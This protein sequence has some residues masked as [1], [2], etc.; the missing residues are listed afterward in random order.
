MSGDAF[1]DF[2]DVQ[3]IDNCEVT[4]LR[5]FGGYPA[6][7]PNA[8]AITIEQEDTRDIVMMPLMLLGFQRVPYLY[9]FQARAEDVP[10]WEPG[11]ELFIYALGDDVPSFRSLLEFPRVVEVRK[12]VHRG[13]Q[14]RLPTIYRDRA[15]RLF[16]SPIEEPVGV[17]ILQYRLDEPERLAYC[18]RCAFMGDQGFGRI[19]A[20]ALEGLDQD[21][22]LEDDS[23]RTEAYVNGLRVARMQRDNF[24]VVITVS[25]GTGFMLNVQ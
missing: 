20:R 22:A 6:W 25:I 7:T 3:V 24:D 12:V 18:V 23:S 14:N 5:D 4:D 2:P 19:P 17:S 1:G 21:D 15:L 8:G 11:D 9:S 13:A 10:L 16:W